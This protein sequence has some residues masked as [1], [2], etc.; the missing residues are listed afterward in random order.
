MAGKRGTK[1]KRASPFPEAV[2]AAPA[3]ARTR[4]ALLELKVIYRAID[5]L[6]QNVN[7]HTTTATSASEAGQ[8]MHLS[9]VPSLRLIGT[10]YLCP[11]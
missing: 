2:A 11:L 10:Q 8:K 3:Q 9:L 4:N 1:A 5:L 6:W 7:A